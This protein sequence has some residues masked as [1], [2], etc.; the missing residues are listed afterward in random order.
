M[1]TASE[2]LFPSASEC[3][4]AALTSSIDKNNNNNNNS[5][6]MLRDVVLWCADA[7][8]ELANTSLLTSDNDNDNKN[9]NSNTIT[10][11]VDVLSEI[12]LSSSS[13]PSVK[14]M[15]CPTTLHF[16]YYENNNNN[17]NNIIATE[18]SAFFYPRPLS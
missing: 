15:G 16:S 17:N 8:F 7:N 14:K 4:R 5:V 12:Y 11:I 18:R 10:K 9:D 1:S 13:T 3:I 2:W 6:S